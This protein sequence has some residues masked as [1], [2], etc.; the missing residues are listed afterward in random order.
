MSETHCYLDDLTVF[1]RQT[2]HEIIP[3]LYPVPLYLLGRPL[4]LPEEADPSGTGNADGHRIVCVNE[5]F[6]DNEQNQFRVVDV[7]GNGTFS[8]V[9]KCQIVSDPSTFVALKVI[10]NLRPY[11]ATGISEVM[12][13]QRMAAAP[14]CKGKKHVINP[15]SSFEVEGHVCLVLPLYNRS[16]FEGLCQTQAL[17]ELLGT[18]RNIMQQLLTALDFIH[19]IGIMHCDLKPDNILFSDE[20]CKNISLIDFGSSTNCGTNDVQYIQSRFYRSPEVILGLPYDNLI[21]I[22][23]AGC[24]AAEL[25]LDFALF[26]CENEFDTIHSM[27]ALLGPIPEHLLSKSQNWRRFFDMNHN[28]FCLKMDP[29]QVLLTNHSYN[30][31]FEQIGA[32]PLTQLI[33][34]H[35]LILDQEELNMIHSFDH[36]IHSLLKFDTSQRLTA[37]QALSH[38]FILNEHFTEGWQPPKVIRSNTTS[39]LRGLPRNKP[40][41]SSMGDLG[42]MDFLNLL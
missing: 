16:L 29:I 13:H 34:E 15:I 30:Q 42:T 4:N 19:G 39:K 33:H 11:R 7:L 41:T 17:T 8:Y 25:F 24:V 6:E 27:V 3:D 5:I 28:G 10:K 35:C 37:F 1:I 12:V 2:Y 21:D 38:P 36:F 26:A 22:W 32:V 20:E 9:F 18:I 23:S 40:Q 31:I 14:D